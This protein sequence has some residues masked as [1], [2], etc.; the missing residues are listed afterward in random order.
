MFDSMK[1]TSYWTRSRS[2]TCTGTSP[3]NLFHRRY[4]WRNSGPHSL[5]Y[6]RT[7]YPNSICCPCPRWLYECP[8]SRL[9]RRHVHR[10][11][12]TQIWPTGTLGRVFDMICRRSLR[13]RNTK[14]FVF[15]E[16]YE[17][18]NKGFE[19]QTCTGTSPPQFVVSITL[20]YCVLEMIKKV[21]TD[22]IR[23]LVKPQA[24]WVDSGG[25]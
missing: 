25:N 11:S 24:W 13:T 18:L 22:P 15:Y 12:K 1:P 23:I 3:R 4:H 7:R 2:T 8:M 14:K 19:E 9:Y 10:H 17:L 21:M 6:S 16:A 20:P 5:S